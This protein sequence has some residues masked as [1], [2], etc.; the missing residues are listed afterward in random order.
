MKRLVHLG[1]KMCGLVASFALILG[2]ASVQA[3]CVAWFHQP[4]VPQGMSKFKR[5]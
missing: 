5:H 2:V 4:K 3:P 1:K